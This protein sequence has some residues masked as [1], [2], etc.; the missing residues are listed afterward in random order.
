M[1]DSHAHI[2]D[3]Q[4][5]EDLDN[6]ISASKSLGVRKILMPNIDTDSIE[7]MMDLADQYKGYCL[8]MMGLHPCSVDAQFEEALEIIEDWLSK[9]PFVAVGE[10]GTDLY[11]DKTYWHQ[12][13]IAFRRQCEMALKNSLPIVIHSRD[14]IDETIE[15]VRPFAE[16]GLKGVFHCFTG[17]V[18]QAEQIKKMGFYLGIGGVVTF[19][20]SGLDAVLEQI[21]MEKLILETDSP[22]LAPTPHRGKRNT[23]VFLSLINRKIAEI[24]DVPAGEISRLTDIN[25]Q[26]LFGLD[27]L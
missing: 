5:K 9:Y 13:Q 10:M 23:P 25:V 7:K 26:A 2:Y 3:D 17:T 21:G 27:E 15:L 4:F 20:N 8:P 11:W 24:M 6:I 18:S 14:S 12:Q 22:Y 1:I 16:K 19:K